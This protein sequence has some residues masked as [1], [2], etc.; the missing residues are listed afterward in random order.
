M[1]NPT[2]EQYTDL[3]SKLTY[4][5]ETIRSEVEEKD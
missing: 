5:N 2:I 3:N 4:D 1:I